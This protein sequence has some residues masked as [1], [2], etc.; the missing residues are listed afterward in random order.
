MEKRLNFFLFSVEIDERTK[1]VSNYLTPSLPL[2]CND[3]GEKAKEGHAC[4]AGL[5]SSSSPSSPPL[6]P[7]SSLASPCPVL[8]V[9]ISWSQLRNC[10]CVAWWSHDLIERQT[11]RLSSERASERY[12]F[13]PSREKSWKK[14][15]T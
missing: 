10:V 9:F 5:S 8:C 6:S 1:M 4:E 14:D 13:C 11:E 2:P 3:V 12:M 15:E 7:S